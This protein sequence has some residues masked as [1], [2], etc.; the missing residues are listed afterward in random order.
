M[1]QLTPEQKAIVYSRLRDGVAIRN[2]AGELG[3][4]RNTV[5]LAKQKLARHGTIIRKTGSG[6]PKN[7]TPEEDR[8]LVNYLMKRPFE[9]AIKAKEE[10]NFPGSA[11]TARDRVRNSEMRS[12]CAANIFF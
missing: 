4:N 8:R 7:F 5:L 2:I 9:T 3:V 11:N 12:R 1:P 10:T 6:P